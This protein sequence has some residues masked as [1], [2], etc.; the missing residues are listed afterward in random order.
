[1][2][3]VEILNVE[4]NDIMLGDY[5]IDDHHHHQIYLPMMMNFDE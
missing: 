2:D 3:V 4:I 5:V 1:M